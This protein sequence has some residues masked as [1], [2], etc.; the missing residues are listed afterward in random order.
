MDDVIVYPSGVCIQAI[1]NTP[2]PSDYF[3]SPWPKRRV[4]S[5]AISCYLYGFSGYFLYAPNLRSSYVCKCYFL[6]DSSYEDKVV[7]KMEISP[8]QDKKDKR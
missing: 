6:D 5:K 4:C 2:K 7:I 3:S 8:K 1:F